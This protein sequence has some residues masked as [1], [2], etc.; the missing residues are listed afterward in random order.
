MPGKDRVGG[1]WKI[2]MHLQHSPVVGLPEGW[3]TSQRDL[4]RLKQWA[5]VKLIRFNKS[6]C[7]VLHLGCGNAHYLIQAGVQKNRVQHCQK[8][9]GGSG[10]WEDGHELA[11]A[12]AAWASSKR[13]WLADL[14]GDSAP[15]LCAYETSPGV[16]STD[17]ESSVQERCGPVGTSPEE[18]H[19][20]DPRDETPSLQGQAGR[21]GAV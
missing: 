9:L 8:G 19:K 7:K 15:L 14:E 6:K 18:G 1:V 21:A 20:D 2:L 17:V 16:L 11:Y 3:D 10:G 4:E 12:I 13:V 5:Q